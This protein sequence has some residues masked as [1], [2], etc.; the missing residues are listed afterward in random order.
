MKKDIVIK[1]D[2]VTMNF[3]LAQEQF[4]GLKDL[5]IMFTKGKLKFN[6]FSALKNVSLEIRRG[7]S[8]GLIGENGCGKS[9]LLKVISGIYR[10]SSGNVTVNGSIA[11]L[12]ELGAGFDL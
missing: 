9:T 4:S 8:W 2:N 3:N 5:F 7:E 10:P 11:P 1:L 12:S 6:K